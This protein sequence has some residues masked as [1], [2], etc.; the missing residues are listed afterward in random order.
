MDELANERGPDK[1]YLAGAERPGRWVVRSK[2]VYGRARLFSWKDRVVDCKTGTFLWQG[3][4]L[5]LLYQMAQSPERLAE[6]LFS[7]ASHAIV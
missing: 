3:V 7:L 2:E 6:R 1:G 5:F 4:L